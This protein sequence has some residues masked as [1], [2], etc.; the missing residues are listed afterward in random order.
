MNKTLMQK[1]V[2]DYEKF[3]IPKE[4]IPTYETPQKFATDI[5]KCSIFEYKHVSYSNN[6]SEIGSSPVYPYNK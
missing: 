2:N 4:K 6:A 5:K 3:G 1:I